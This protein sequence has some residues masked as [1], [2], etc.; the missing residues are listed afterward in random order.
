MV[1]GTTV[2]TLPIST[3]VVV[4]VCTRIHTAYV[5]RSALTHMLYARA[6]R[7]MGY[8]KGKY[9]QAEGKLDKWVENGY[10]SPFGG[11]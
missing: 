8:E 2:I 3:H 11:N 9:V 10:Y 4:P 7:N 6:L 5:L 1:Q